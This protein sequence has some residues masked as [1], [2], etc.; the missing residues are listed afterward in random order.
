VIFSEEQYFTLG[1]GLGILAFMVMLLILHRLDMKMDS[2][3]DEDQY[4]PMFRGLGVVIVYMWLLGVN[5]YG[6]IKCRINYR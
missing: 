4:F 3:I 1:N 2:K 6:W 5:V